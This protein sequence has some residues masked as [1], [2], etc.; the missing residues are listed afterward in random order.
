[1]NPLNVDAIICLSLDLR[2]DLWRELEKQCLDKG[3]NYK[4]FI[5]GGGGDRG[6]DP[7]LKYDL[8]DTDEMPP[9]YKQSIQYPTWWKRPN[10]YR[11]WKSH[12]KMMEFSLEKEYKSV[13]FLEDDI[14]LVDGFDE[15]LKKIEKRIDFYQP[16][17]DM[18]YLGSFVNFDKSDYEDYMWE[19]LKVE[20]NCGGWHAVCLTEKVMK[21]LLKFPP[22]G[23]YDWV[24]QNYIQRTHNCYAA[25]EPLVRQQ[26]T[27]SWVEGHWLGRREEDNY[28]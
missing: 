17:I 26:G 1:M 12:R 22:L 28:Q 27:F 8:I 20:G 21:E 11:A 16:S 14:I 7:E 2:K 4:S 6:L 10:A 5:C 24:C 13:L 18:Y 15:K 19:S 9:A 23:P 3:W 25:I